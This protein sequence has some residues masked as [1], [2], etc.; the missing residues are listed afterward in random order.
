MLRSTVPYLALLALRYPW[1]ESNT[2][3]KAG[4]DFHVA[5]APERTV[6]G[7]ALNELRDLPQIVGGF[8]ENVGPLLQPL[9]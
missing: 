4:I 3:L 7:D 5:F 6:E 1:L 2:D 8:T 9:A